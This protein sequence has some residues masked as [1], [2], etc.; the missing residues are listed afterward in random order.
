MRWRKLRSQLLQPLQLGL[1]VRA[2]L[3]AVHPERGDHPGDDPVPVASDR[4]CH[5][6]PAGHGGHAGNALHQGDRIRQRHDWVP[7]GAVGVLRVQALPD[8]PG[9]ERAAP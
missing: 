6:V 5:G 1:H 3:E 8:A 2:L 9:T 7:S 4:L